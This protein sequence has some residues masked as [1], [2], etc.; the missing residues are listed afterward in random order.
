M[1]EKTATMFILWWPPGPRRRGNLLRI[2]QCAK[3]ER[4]NS[5]PLTCQAAYRTNAGGVFGVRPQQQGQRGP[6]VLMGVLL[7]G[8]GR[9]CCNWIRSFY[10]MMG[11][12][13]LIPIMCMLI[14]FIHYFH[15]SKM[16]F[17]FIY[18]GLYQI[19]F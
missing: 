10:I 14:E 19:G 17:Y 16:L 1:K 9:K 3:Q 15:H 8:K 4:E 11:L 13:C 7:C 2:T 18:S 12:L 5:R 6:C